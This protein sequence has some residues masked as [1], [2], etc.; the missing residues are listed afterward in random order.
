[1]EF[2]VRFGPLQ[3]TLKLAGAYARGQLFTSLAGQQE[4][5]E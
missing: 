4:A 3:I 5:A 2:Q 1:M